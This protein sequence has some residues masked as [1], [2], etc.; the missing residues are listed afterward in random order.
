MVHAV[1]VSQG[2]IYS[3]ECPSISEAIEF[4]KEDSEFAKR[5][6]VGIYNPEDHSVVLPESSSTGIDDEAQL[7]KIQSHFEIDDLQ[8]SAYFPYY[9]NTK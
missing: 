7:R 3:E 1:Y 4:L 6:P 8:V 5:H 2:E 9:Q